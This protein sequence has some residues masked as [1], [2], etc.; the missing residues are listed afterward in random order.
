M[1]LVMARPAD[2]RDVAWVGTDVLQPV[3]TLDLRYEVMTRK[4]FQRTADFTSFQLRFFDHRAHFSDI[5]QSVIPTQRNT[6][7]VEHPFERLL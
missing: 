5:F 6:W 3:L 2:N 1:Y 4:I 7:L